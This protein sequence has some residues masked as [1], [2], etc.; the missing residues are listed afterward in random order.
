MLR[1]EADDS[2]A[3]FPKLRTTVELFAGAGGL[4]FGIE[5]AGFKTL[6]LVEFDRDAADILK[7]N[8][9][10]WWVIDENITNISC[11]DLSVNLAYDIAKEI[12]QSL[13]GLN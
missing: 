7:A 4:A 12:H 10:N 11:L 9:P 6:G 5:K 2:A 13:E 3:V 8:R 1:H